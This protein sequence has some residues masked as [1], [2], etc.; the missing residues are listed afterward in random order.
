MAIV[1]FTPTHITHTMVGLCGRS[2]ALSAAFADGLALGV[3][4]RRRRR[5]VGLAMAAM[6]GRKFV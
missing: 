1:V 5:R 6:N 3:C 2:T 4:R